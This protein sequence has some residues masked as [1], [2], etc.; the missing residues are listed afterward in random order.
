MLNKYSKWYFNIIDKRSKLIYNGYTETHHILPRSLG[1]S[2]DASNLVK[3]SAREHFICHLLLVKMQTTKENKDKMISAAIGM[4]YWKPKASNRTYKINSRIFQKLK[5][6][7]SKIVSSRFLSIP[8]TESHKNKI[9]KSGRG[10]HDHKKEKNPMYGKKHSDKVREDSRQRLAKT[11]SL[12]K[13]YTNGEIN[14]FSIDCPGDDWKLG[15][16][17][18]PTSK[19]FKWYN[20]G[21]IQKTSLEHPG[22][23]WVSGMLK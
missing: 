17:V 1:G 19:G 10:K 9:S 22:A 11:N 8:K 6:E 7:N 12:R 16:I 23:G 18:K 5:E 2:N 21:I 3:L 14:K 4:C 13:W 15:R 20:N